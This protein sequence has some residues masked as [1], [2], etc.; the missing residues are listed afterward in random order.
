LAG[1]RKRQAHP[2]GEQGRR[3][4]AG[5]DDEAVDGKGALGVGRWA[6]GVGGSVLGIRYWVFGI[7]YSVF[8]VRPS[9]FVLGP[10]SLVVRLSTFVVRGGAPAGRG[11]S[12]VGRGDEEPDGGRRR[13]DRVD[14]DSFAE[15][16]TGREGAAGIRADAAGGAEEAAL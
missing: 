5:G 8:G 7:R 15:F 12:V 9:S 16:G 11:Q 14:L 6:L 1:D 13:L 3:P 2:W 10:S 4:R